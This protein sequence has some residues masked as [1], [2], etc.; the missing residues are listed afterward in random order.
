MGRA[1]AR[2]PVWPTVVVCDRVVDNT[3]VSD[4]HGTIELKVNLL[5]SSND[6][7]SRAVDNRALDNRATVERM[8]RGPL[9][10]HR[11][12]ALSPCWMR[13]PKIARFLAGRRPV[14]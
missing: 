9:V 6:E 4:R 14:L 5:M 3:A 10:L 13:L 7:V 8:W 1:D 11:T 2:R 12:N